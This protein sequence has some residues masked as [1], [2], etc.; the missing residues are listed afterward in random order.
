MFDFEALAL[1]CAEDSV[2][3]LLGTVSTLPFAGTAGGPAG[4]VAIRSGGWSARDVGRAVAAIP[5]PDADAAGVR[6]RRA[7]HRRH[8]VLDGPLP[9]GSSGARR[10]T[11][12]LRRILLGRRR[13]SP[14]VTATVSPIRLP[15]FDGGVEI[16]NMG[17]GGF[18]PPSSRV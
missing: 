5:R 7:L 3:D 15:G 11:P 18:E 6:R 10:E 2:Y 16:P 8:A 12:E 1:A 9:A 13:Q 4:P 17:A 14:E